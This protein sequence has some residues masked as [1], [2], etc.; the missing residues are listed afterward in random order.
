MRT[1]STIGT[2]YFI[3]PSGCQLP[4]P[5]PDFPTAF[6]GPGFTQSEVFMSVAN[7]WMSH[8]DQRCRPGMGSYCLK[9]SLSR[10]L[11]VEKSALD[12]ILR[13]GP[14][15]IFLKERCGFF[16]CVL[17]KGNVRNLANQ[18]KDPSIFEISSSA[19]AIERSAST[20]SPGGRVPECLGHTIS[21][22][23]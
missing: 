16:G 1:I 11:W 3:T 19:S 21:A 9:T 2:I 15:G 6:K 10:K 23:T 8:R 17:L 18:T 7:A 22:T 5:A 13:F 12:S 14:N 20:T 4:L